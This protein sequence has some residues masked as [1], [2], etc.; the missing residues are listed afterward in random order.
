MHRGGSRVGPMTGGEKKGLAYALKARN[1]SPDSSVCQPGPVPPALLEAS[2]SSWWGCMWGGGWSIGL[3]C[4]VASFWPRFRSSRTPAG[5]PSLAVASVL[6]QGLCFLFKR[7]ASHTSLAAGP[8]ILLLILGTLKGDSTTGLRGGTLTF[9]A[10][11]R[12]GESV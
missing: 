12:S 6:C 10:C 9:S 11:T 7:A 2:F 1:P 5:A 4:F 8:W 3:D